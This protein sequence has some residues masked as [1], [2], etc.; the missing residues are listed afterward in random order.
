MLGQIGRVMTR[1]L[2]SLVLGAIP[3]ALYAGLVGAVHLGVYGRWDRMPAFAV[4][5]ILVGALLGLLGC[6]VWSSCDHPMQK[7]VLVKASA[8]PEVY[9]LRNGALPA[10]RALQG[11]SE[12][13]RFLAKEPCAGLM[14][15]RNRPD[16]AWERRYA[17]GRAGTQRTTRAP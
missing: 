17:T 4:G 7:P 2:V 11:K 1:V 8:T 13:G 15:W 14:S 3:G 5:C 16:S 9:L 6:S 12:P 10:D